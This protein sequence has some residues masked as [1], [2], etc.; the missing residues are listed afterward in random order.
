MRL[1]LPAALAVWTL[2]A[3]L[4][5]QSPSFE[6]RLAGAQGR[7][8]LALLMEA[9]V[10][11]RH[12][13]ATRA[14]AYAQEAEALAGH[15]GDRPGWLEARRR[16]GECLGSLGRF[17]E[18][19]QVL[20]EAER[21]ALR[22]QITRGLWFNLKAQ[23]NF[24]D[25]L[26]QF[27]A[28]ADVVSR[29]IQ[30]AQ[31]EGDLHGIA[32]TQFQLGIVDFRMKQDDKAAEAWTLA[33]ASFEKAQDKAGQGSALRNLGVLARHRHAYG[34]ALDYF[35]R[36]I[37]IASAQGSEQS[38]SQ[39]YNNL[40]IVYYDQK[41]WKA[42]E[43]YYLKALDIQQRLGDP[44]S[45]ALECQNLADL[46]RVMGQIPKGRP[47]LDRARTLSEQVKAQDIIAE[48]YSTESEYA[49]DLGDF[50]GALAWHRKFSDVQQALFTQSTSEKMAAL[51]T[52]FDFDRKQ[53]EIEMLRKDQA[54]RRA[55]SRLYGVALATLAILGLALLNRYRLK[56]RSQREIA[57][58]NRNLEAIDA[59]VR[60]I[61]HQSG[62]EELARDLLEQG[63]VLVPGA[64][65]LGLLLLDPSR[66]VFRPVAALSSH[67]E[68]VSDLLAVELPLGEA[69][70]RY[71]RNSG[72]CPGPAPWP[73]SRIP[74]PCSS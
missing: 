52:R 42:C 46:Y 21:Q 71:T 6:A 19:L 30:L 48:C 58:K 54:V 20:R 13:D 65:R 2:T 5:A 36:A 40:A 69:V 18:A 45:V 56:V 66:G 51:Q 33:L 47:F 44:K 34:E 32:E 24:L 8:R 29:A 37:Q 31:A 38:L 74:R 28:C 10:P 55:T 49:A 1:S 12:G 41:K 11:N 62:L 73:A 67:P 59:M 60:S 70:E 61:N 64:D 14:M 3:L 72:S 43:A 39:V 57:R 17:E 9:A 23:A 50:R 53:R 63:Q 15:L 16:E 7:A 26:A 27:E 22:W 35:Q 4:A 25:D 68:E